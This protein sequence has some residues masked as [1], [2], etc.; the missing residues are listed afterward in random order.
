M[1]PFETWDSFVA[2]S[3]G[4]QEEYFNY[5]TPGIGFVNQLETGFQ[6]D[7]IDGKNNYPPSWSTEWMSKTWDK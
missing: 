6:L 3:W 2:V 1:F 4:S 7:I 5:A